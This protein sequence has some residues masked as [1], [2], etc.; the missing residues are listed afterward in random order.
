MSILEEIHVPHETVNDQVVNVVAIYFQPGDKVKSGDVVMD[1]ETSKTVMEIRAE[2][3]GFVEYCCLLGEDVAVGQVVAKVHDLSSDDLKIVKQK[4]A[5]ES[6]VASHEAVFSPAALAYISEHNINKELFRGMDF[7]SLDDAKDIRASS[8]PEAP[9]T[10]VKP[11]VSL[12]DKYCPAVELVK[13]SPSKRS[14]IVYLFDVQ[15]S[16][17][18]SS[19]TVFVNV[20]NVFDF[21]NEQFNVF[22]TSML[23]LVVYECSRLLKR[24]K[25]F[26][27]YFAGDCIAYYKEVNVGLAINVDDG[28]KVVKIQTPDQKQLKVIEEEMYVMFEKYLDKKLLIGDVAGT[29]FTITDLSSEGPLFFSPLINKGQSAILGVSA[30]DQEL[31]R[32]LL[33]LTFDHRVADGKDASQFLRDLKTRIES[34]DLNQSIANDVAPRVKDVKC[35]TCFKSLQEDKKMQGVGFVRVL[36][37]DGQTGYSCLSCLLG[38]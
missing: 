6:G 16:C 2:K 31:K 22:K 3:D 29:T 1:L 7:V 21:I 18:N 23:P 38:W 30:V 15:Q 35:K 13:L 25:S 27:A 5:G 8:V 10:G 36:T 12:P 26:N 20:E 11:Q 17:L 37:H 34:Y 19:V 28:L 9:P 32:V 14:E 24:F 4:S 33:T